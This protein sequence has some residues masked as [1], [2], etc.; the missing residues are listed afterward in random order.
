MCLWWLWKRLAVALV[1][2]INQM[3]LP[4]GGW[5][6]SSPPR[7]WTTQNV[8]DW[9]NWAWLLELCHGS[10][11]TRGAPGSRV[12]SWTGVYT[13]SSWTLKPL[14]HTTSFPGLP[15]CRWQVMGLLSLP[16]TWANTLLY[17]YTCFLNIYLTNISYWFFFP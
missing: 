14:N 13:I 9:N 10:S 3:T 5:A 12:Q 8:E 2:W 16:I 17:L 11:L 4:Q 7:S 6:L 15:A 1:N